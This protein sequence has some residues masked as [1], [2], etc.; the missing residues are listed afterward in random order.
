[1]VSISGI[2]IN[3]ADVQRLLNSR[4]ASIR[5]LFN[6]PRNTHRYFL[7]PISGTA[8]IKTILLEPVLSRADTGGA[9]P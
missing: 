7:E 5:I 1:M 8:H 2:Y 4:N 6:L 3:S 9:P